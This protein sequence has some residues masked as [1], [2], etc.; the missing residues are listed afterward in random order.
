VAKKV[1]P[2]TV[3][4]DWTGQWQAA[5]TLQY[6]DALFQTT[7]LLD[8][9]GMVKMMNDDPSVEHLQTQQERYVD[10]ARVLEL[11]AER[12]LGLTLTEL[13]KHP[14]DAKS[15]EAL[16]RLYSSLKR[17]KEA[18]AAQE[19]WITAFR[20]TTKDAE[21]QRK[22]LPGAYLS[23][24]W[25]QLH[26]RDFAGALASCDAG[27]AIDPSYL[28]LDTNRAHALL[29]LGRTAEAIAL[30]QEHSGKSMKPFLDRTWDQEILNDFDVLESEG[31]KH[32]EW[33][34]IRKLLDAG[35]K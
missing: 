12:R 16:P 1:S 7:L 11:P 27:R 24:S 21:E 23:L 33:P 14:D 22:A 9:N 13:E 6:G 3:W 15:L 5:G 10:G 25:Y 32:P 8:R 2:L 4:Q 19:R 18:L 34:R 28:P 31:L 29:F 17:W 20:G 30:Y 35:R 26:T